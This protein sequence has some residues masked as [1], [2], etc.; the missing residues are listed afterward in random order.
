MSKRL[1]NRRSGY[2]PYTRLAAAAVRRA[3]QDYHQLAVALESPLLTT[4]KA[5]A[6]ETEAHALETWLMDPHNPFTSQA[7]LTPDTIARFIEGA[8]GELND[9]WSLNPRVTYGHLQTM[10]QRQRELE[11]TGD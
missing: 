5:H 11:L 6:L 2:D 4:D 9:F 8:G 7:A 1:P 3:A 10:R